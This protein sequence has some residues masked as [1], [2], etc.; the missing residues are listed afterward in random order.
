MHPVCFF[1]SVLWGFFTALICGRTTESCPHGAEPG[2]KPDK[3]NG[4]RSLLVCSRPPH[5]APEKHTWNG[6][7]CSVPPPRTDAAGH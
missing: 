7:Q 5:P 4:E 6:R 2:W 1:T 3:V